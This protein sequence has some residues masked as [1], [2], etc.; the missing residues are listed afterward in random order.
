MSRAARSAAGCCPAMGFP[1]TE[2][3]KADRGGWPASADRGECGTPAG[4]GDAAS[5]AWGRA[6]IR[7]ESAAWPG[8][9]DCAGRANLPRALRGLSQVGRRQRPESV[10]SQ[11]AGVT[12]LRHRDPG[13]RRYGDAGVR[14]AAFGRSDLGDSRFCGVARPALRRDVGDRGHGNAVPLQ[15]IRCAQPDRHWRTPK[16]SYR[17]SVIMPGRLHCICR[18]VGAQPNS[19]I[20]TLPTSS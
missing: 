7:D 19:A 14:G 10:R 9:R 3:R 13:A 18:P 12:V 8:C 16:A 20:M 17:S 2:G 6:A 4:G 11:A 1:P 15:V 5:T